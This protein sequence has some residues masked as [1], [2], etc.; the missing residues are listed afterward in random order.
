[1]S[2][3]K[4]FSEEELKTR[5]TDLRR[6]L[7]AE[8]AAAC[9]AAIQSETDAE[10]REQL[11]RYAIRK[12]GGGSGASASD[13]DAMVA[14][15]SVATSKTGGREPQ[16]NVMA[17]NLS[18]NLCDCWGDGDSRQRAH[19]EAGLRFADLALELRRILKKDASS[20]S[21][22][23]WARGKH[24][25]SLGRAREAA[26]A[27]Q[28]SL[29]CERIAAR[30]NGQDPSALENA[31]GGLL[32]SRAFLGLSMARSGRPEGNAML[33]ESLAILRH[34]IEKGEGE[35]KEDA[36]VYLDQIQESL[37]RA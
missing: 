30:E 12:L 3:D 33:E 10:R 21:M 4:A 15:G 17:F 19:F 29:N 20:F 24:L 9:C 22:A 32:N 8:G 35:M 36:Q 7:D 31:S 34:R 13:L 6:T 5:W 23:H 2:S 18:A 1:M 28:E 25:L 14:I 26:E 16:V 37:K 11:F 27:F